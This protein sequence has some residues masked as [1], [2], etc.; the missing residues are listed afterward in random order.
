M[1]G[2]LRVTLWSLCSWAV[3]GICVAIWLPMMAI[4]WLVTAPFDKGRYWTGFLFRKLAVVHQR[5][6]PLWH[7]R[8]TGTLPDDPRRPY[9]V[10]SNHESFVDIL[11]ISHLPWEMKWL[12]KVEMFK[13]PVVGWLMRMAGDVPVTRGTADSAVEALR[14]CRDRLDKRVS[15]MVFPEGTRAEEGVLLPFKDG[16]FRLAIEAGTPVLPLAVAGT[17]TA[18]RKHSWRLGDS[19]A[20]VRVLEPISTEGLTLADVAMLREQA[21][22][23]IGAGLKELRAEAACSH[24]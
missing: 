1:V 7:F 21:R 8:V 24:Q 12:S 20:V 4:V 19:T 11:L 5:L 6:T 10:V 16:A 3:L 23:R 2:G 22:D 9:V 15:V 17:A 13:I 14:Q 18:L